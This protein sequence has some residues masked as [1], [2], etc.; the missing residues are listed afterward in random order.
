MAL[1]KDGGKEFGK[2]PISHAEENV[3]LKGFVMLWKETL[4]SVWA[5]L[6]PPCFAATSTSSPKFIGKYNPSY[7]TRTC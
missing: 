6:D 1:G 2:R 4:P 3:L 7:C 5:G